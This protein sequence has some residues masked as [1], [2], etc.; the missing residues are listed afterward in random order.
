MPQ[1]NQSTIG[2]AANYQMIGFDL[3][4][5]SYLAF[6]L[7]FCFVIFRIDFNYLGTWMSLAGSIDRD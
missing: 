5:R 2:L 3:K 1:F 7:F 6:N 4:V